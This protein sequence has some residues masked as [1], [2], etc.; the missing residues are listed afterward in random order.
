MKLSTWDKIQLIYTTLALLC[1]IFFIAK[2]W[3]SRECSLNDVFRKEHFEG[4]IV[5]L[6]SN[7]PYNHGMSRFR[8]NTNYYYSWSD[9]GEEEF[10]HLL[11]VGD[12]VS[13]QKGSLLLEVFTADS[14][15]IVDL[16]L[17]CER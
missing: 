10:F 8:L 7:P 12:S 17:P 5:D 2:P 1:V 6:D 13:K 3:Q 15:F 9:Y 14:T 11:D 4:I 16:S